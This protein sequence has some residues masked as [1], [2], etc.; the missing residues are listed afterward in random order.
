MGK[1]VTYSRVRDEIRLVLDSGTAVVM[2]R[3]A[4]RELRALPQ[5]HMGRLRLISDGHVVALEL[6]DVHIYVPGLVRDMTGYG[7][8][9]L[10]PRQIAQSRRALRKQSPK[11]K[12]RPRRAPA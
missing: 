7:S 11:R 3:K 5:S 2:P 6:D 12:A 10:H 8:R 9:A 4:I 1:S